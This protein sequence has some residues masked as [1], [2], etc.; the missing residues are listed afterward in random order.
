M[1]T[2]G[3]GIIGAGWV[4]SEHIKA[5]KQNPHTEVRAISS[6]TAEGA[7]KK[8]DDMGLLD[9]QVYDATED[10]I[11]SG[12]IDMVTICSP[13][14]LHPEQTV[15]A[16]RKKLHVIIEKPVAIDLEGLK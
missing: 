10:L 13:N 15:M 5:F 9:C 11:E 8:A 7:R 6:R 16:A 14:Y 3:V 2:F 4:A 12:D 1:E